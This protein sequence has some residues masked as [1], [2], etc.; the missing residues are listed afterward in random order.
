LRPRER[1]TGCRLA[2]AAWIPLLLALPGFAA[3]AAEP[4]RAKSPAPASP[5]PAA[6]SEMVAV[7][8]GPFFYGCFDRADDACDSDERPSGKFT[9]P[10][11]AIDRTEVTVAAYR[12]CV[13]AK[14]CSLPPVS[15]PPACNWDKPDRDEHPINCVELADARKYCAWAGKRVPSETEWEKAARGIDGRVYPWGF[16]TFEKA[17]PV[18]NIADRTSGL[19]WQAP[20]YDDGFAETAPVGSYPKGASPYGALD[21]IGNVW[22]WTDN[23]YD[24]DGGLAVRGGSWRTNRHGCRNSNRLWRRPGNTAAFFGFRCAR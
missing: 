8:A 14:A 4:P 12:R 19:S 1:K 21:M 23:P 17:G 15:A 13:E 3:A 6:D 11:Y 5:A 20:D 16:A 2:A 10:A 22:E 18:A 7:P 24:R 9:L